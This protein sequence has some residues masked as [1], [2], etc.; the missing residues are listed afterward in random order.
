MIAT[1]G[2]G[3]MVIE[4]VHPHPDR[5]PAGLLA[6]IGAGVEDLVGQ[7]AVVPLHLPVVPRRVGLDALVAA[8]E[9]FHAAGE[10][11][12]P[13]VGAVVGHDPVQ[14]PDAMGGEEGPRPAEERRIQA[15]S[16]TSPVRWDSH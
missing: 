1:G 16:A 11:A 2:M 15:V 7:Q 8:G 14:P 9:G 6:G 4:V 13:V 10:V 5:V 3:P 12:G